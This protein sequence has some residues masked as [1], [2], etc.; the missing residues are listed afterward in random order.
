[1]RS[2]IAYQTT[3]AQVNKENLTT[4]AHLAITDTQ[5]LTEPFAITRVRYIPGSSQRGLNVFLTNRGFQTWQ[6]R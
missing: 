2:S 1:M 3:K 6:Q 4:T 5:N